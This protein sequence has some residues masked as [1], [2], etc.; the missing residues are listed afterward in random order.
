MGRY[1]FYGVVY[2]ERAYIETTI[3]SYLAEQ[4]FCDASDLEAD[5]TI[6][7][8]NKLSQSPYIKIMTY[9]ACII[10]ATS[11]AI[12]SKVKVAFAGK[13]RDEIFEF[14]FVY[15]QT[16]HYIPDGKRFERQGM[17]HEFSYELL[18]GDEVHTLVGLEGFDNSVAFDDNG[19]TSTKIVLLAK[20]GNEI[21]GLAGAGYKTDKIW[22]V[23]IDIKPDYRQ[24]G[25]G[26]KLVNNLTA[27]IMAQG[28]VPLYSASV[29][30]IGSQIVAS[31]SGY[32]AC[33]VDTYG[34]IL[35][36]SSVYQSFVKDLIL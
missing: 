20:K 5:H 1:I 27:E 19:C 32:V 10:V 3:K 25:L 34:N 17:P 26:T 36:G 22:E 15:G 29:T 33:W 12:R 23:G 21:I 28:I 31:R 11:E 7:T 13:S 6:F 16:I 4:Y 14:P 9:K 30:N 2:M 35:D 24:W 8:V 18:Q